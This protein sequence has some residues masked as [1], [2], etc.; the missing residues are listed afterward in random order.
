MLTRQRRPHCQPRTLLERILGDGPIL[1]PL[2]GISDSPYRRICRSYGAGLLFSEMISAEGLTFG[3]AGSWRMLRFHPDELP[4][5]VQLSSADPDVMAEAARI[6]A[7]LD[8]TAIN[9]NMGCPA[10]KVVKGDKGAGLMRDP[11]LAARVVEAMVSAVDVPVTVK[12]RSGWDMN[13]INAV[14]LA[15]RVQDA[16]AA[17]VIL[18]PRTRTQEYRGR[19]DWTLIAAVKEALTIPVIGNGDVVDG[20]SAKRMMTETGCDR[21][22]IGRASFGRPWIFA[23]IRA[24]LEGHPA[25]PPPAPSEILAILETQLASSLEDLPHIVAVRAMRKHILWYSRGLPNAAA[26]RQHLCS[27]DNAADQLE[28]CRGFFLDRDLDDGPEGP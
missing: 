15:R 9:I 17:A 8:V 14:A 24:A 4:L 27:Q 20:E 12:M 23:E 3:S 19:A 7:D 6:V 1:A 11:D 2:C 26:F 25:P 5:V 18:H 22:M 21:V 28:A 10:R 13:S 16:G